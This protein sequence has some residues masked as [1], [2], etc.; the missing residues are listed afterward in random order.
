M[1]TNAPYRVEPLSSAHDRAAFVCMQEPLTRYFQQQVTQDVRRRITACFV[2]VDTAGAVAGYYTLASSSVWLGDLLPAW[3]SKLPRYP[4][5]PAVRLVRL[6]VATAHQ[7]K[8]LGAAL[9]ANA[10]QRAGM[11]EIAAYALAVDATDAQAAR[12]YAH[13][14][15]MALPQSPLTLVMAL[16]SVKKLV[17]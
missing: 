9:L 16:A 6:A 11:A 8:G 15:F 7:G 14:G 10:L 12:F 17:S 13:H 3:A 1:A 4:T 2:A 5:V